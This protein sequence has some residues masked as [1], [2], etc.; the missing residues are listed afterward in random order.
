LC[1]RGQSELGLKRRGGKAA[2]EIKGLVATSSS[3]LAAGPFA[4]P[5]ELWTK[6]T[7]KVLE[8]KPESTISVKKVRWLRKFDTTLP[9]VNEVALDGNETPLGGASL[10]ALGCNV[11]L[12]Q[13]EMPQGRIW[14]TLG[15]ESFGTLQTVSKDLEATASIL[16]NRGAPE[17]RMGLLG[18]YPAWLKEHIII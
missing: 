8:L 18:S 6:W 4:G 9:V 11:E 5:I 10:A 16:A 15:F 2:V 14:W 7:S 13:I 12:T 1:D 17:L 3:T